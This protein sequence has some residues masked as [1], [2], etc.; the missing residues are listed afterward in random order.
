MRMK[1]PTTIVLAAL[2]AGLL[3]GA[4]AASS[5]GNAAAASAG[6]AALERGGTLRVNF[7]NSDFEYVDPALAY[8]QAGWIVLYATNLNLLSYPDRPAPEGSRLVPEAA[9][10]LPT[11]SRDG[12]TYT[13]TI[14][15][16]L[17]F[18]D[19]SPVTAA[20]FAR[21]L[22]RAADPEQA[23][24]AI[25][26]LHD[27]VGADAF[28]Q[29]RAER[30][31]GVVARGQR[32]QV[33][34]KTAN[35]TFLAEIAMPFFGAVKASTPIDPKGLDVYPSAGPYRIASREP[36]RL[37]VLERNPFYRGDRPANPDRIVITTN[38]DQ[39]QSL[40]Q[41]RAGQADYDIAGLPPSAHDELASAFGVRRGGDGRY[42]VNTQISTTYL[43]LNTSR[44][45]FAKLSLRKA[46]NYAIDR[47]AILRVGGKF[48]GAR[49]DQILPPNM[50]GFRNAH[51]YPIQGADPVTARR[52]ANG[53]DDE[54]TVLHTTSAQS[55]ARAQIV[56]YNL[57]QMGL[58]VR[59]KPQ[60]FGVAIAT[61]GTK[62]ADFDLFLITW[63]SDYPDPF[64]FVNVLLSGTNIQEQNNSNY[65]Y[66]DDPTFNA[67]MA[68]AARLSGD[69]RYEAYGR[70]DVELM[71][72][73]A[74]WVPLLNGNSREFV[75]ARVTN[76][77]YQPVYAGAIL[78]ALA[79]R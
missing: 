25:A 33:R 40:L 21:A 4:P 39:N 77:V 78:N 35:P 26:F 27:V 2:G 7:S 50:R 66:L 5:S 18:S 34:L 47:P 28:N 46:V 41:V 53:A 37:L 79:I 29:G 20:S 14:R 15:P 23:S 22:H 42:F 62:G 60:P 71:R 44:P 72:D 68:A 36:G 61:A 17:R 12:R 38:T 24:P 52:L 13:F 43:A 56:Q 16:G 58:R 31:A 3:A 32:L 70:L 64:D 65:S 75:S 63:A 69:A 9:T 30:I 11:V 45:A 6:G 54:I 55:Q 49:T 8:D 19:G 67:K 10:G 51:L 1:L 76:F 73:A 74:P 48:A 59:L 57:A